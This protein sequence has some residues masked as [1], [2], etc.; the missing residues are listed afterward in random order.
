MELSAELKEALVDELR[1][2]VKRVEDEIDIGKKI[3]FLSAAY[4]GVQRIFNIRFDPE[5]VLI[6]FV[7]N[8]TYVTVLNL[9]KMIETGNEK[10]IQIPED[11]FYRLNGLI[12][13]LATGIEEDKDIYEILKKISVLS[14]S[15]T[16]NGYYLY[17]KGVIEI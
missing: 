4:S 6:H 1:T 9:H 17:R 12:E 7:L 13:E 16:G 10:V 15:L 11:F 14:Y 5:L 3:F 2:V 8:S